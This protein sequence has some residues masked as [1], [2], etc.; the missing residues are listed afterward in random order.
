MGVIYLVR[1]RLTG[2]K[3]AL[4]LI[5]ADKADTESYRKR[6]L[7]EAT[8]VARLK[9]PHTVTLYD[10]GVTSDGL[11]YFTME[12]LKGMSLGDIIK[13]DGALEYRRAVELTIQACHSLE[14]AHGAGVLHRDIKPGNLLVTT[15]REGAECL[16]VLDFGLAKLEASDALPAQT[17]AGV[18]M[19]TPLYM[20]PEQWA[21]EKLDALTDIYSLG[22]VLYEML[23]GRPPFSADNYV[24]LKNKVLS[25]FP[26]P[27]AVA[28]PGTYVPARLEEVVLECL[29][30]SRD[31]RPASARELRARLT[32]AMGAVSDGPP[33]VDR[34]SK[35]VSRST[36]IAVETTATGSDLPPVDSD[37]CEPVQ[38]PQP[39][40]ASRS[41]AGEV[42]GRKRASRRVRPG[43][44]Y[45][46]LTLLSV[47][48][49]SGVSFLS[50]VRWLDER[51]ENYRQV[52]SL[53]RT[54]GRAVIVQMG[55]ED[56]V[57]TLEARG[58]PVPGPDGPHTWRLVDALVL[59]KLADAGAD[60][61]AFDK[62]YVRD[63]PEETGALADAVAYA[64]SRE[65]PVVVATLHV[66]P[67]DKLVKAGAYYGAA[68][69]TTSGF[70][71]TVSSLFAGFQLLDGPDVPSLFVRAY[72]LSRVPPLE[73]GTISQEQTK[74]EEEVLGWGDRWTLMYSSE[75]I[76]TVRISDLLA[77]PDAEVKRAMKGR[78][79]FVGSYEEGADQVKVPPIASLQTAGQGAIHG[80]QLLAT[81]YNQL[82][83]HSRWIPVPPASSRQPRAHSTSTPLGGVGGDRRWCI[84]TALLRCHNMGRAGR[85]TG[86]FPSMGRTTQGTPLSSKLLVGGRCISK[87]YG[88]ILLRVFELGGRKMPTV[89]SGT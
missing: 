73:M 2:R 76:R 7:V 22:V 39:A 65:T 79:V 5:L 49:A 11:P 72:C 46:L 54:P 21:G 40:R 13:R 1:H 45:C 44:S 15:D 84:V 23:A 24:S 70:D 57:L 17:L 87:H 26:E 43:L 12:L 59:K 19:G 8:A 47:L 58:Y 30:K 34:P 38:E 69:A 86:E 68:L 4:K 10:C 51:A 78:V 53:A 63:Y 66:S 41:G 3:E 37:G 36:P 50:P 31:S 6:F 85:G 32:E 62:A 83:A 77:W 25:Q 81:A 74:C 55:Q 18:V 48:V 14:E 71:G 67:P 56:D 52:V 29:A 89:E 9:S 35:P 75:Q 64:S 60:V 28:N 16:K 61:V 20:S 33:L 27:I 88:L 82:D 80:V 42:A